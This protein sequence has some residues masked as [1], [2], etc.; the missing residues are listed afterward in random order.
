MKKSG[1]GYKDN[2][3]HTDRGETTFSSDMRQQPDVA[4]PQMEFLTVNL[5]DALIFQV[6]IVDLYN[7]Q[8]VLL[9]PTDVALPLKD[10][11]GIEFSEKDI[12]TVQVGDL[13][14]HDII[15]CEFKSID[16]VPTAGQLSVLADVDV[17]DA[18]DGQVLTFDFLT[19]KWYSSTISEIVT[20]AIYEEIPTQITV[21]IFQTAHAYI[22]NTL[23]VYLNGIEEQYIS[24]LS[25]TRFSF[26][27]NINPNDTVVVDYIKA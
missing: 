27:I 19:K 25:S 12:V 1:T 15:K 23:K 5:I 13:F 7:N 3:S 18:E 16:Y 22:A 8:P 14:D 2:S 11:I 17:A 9:N 21:R 10:F 26:G 20:G 4:L 24:K 6:Q